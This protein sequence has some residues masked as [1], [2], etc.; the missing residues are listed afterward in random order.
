[1]KIYQLHFG[2]ECVLTFHDKK[3][4][5][6]TCDGILKITLNMSIIKELEFMQKEVFSNPDWFEKFNKEE[7]NTPFSDIYNIP[8]YFINLALSKINI[9]ITVFEE[10]LKSDE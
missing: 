8:L 10:E 9:F 2:Q 1:M 5:I 6:D 3:T 7:M 4:C